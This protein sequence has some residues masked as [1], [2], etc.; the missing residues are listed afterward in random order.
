MRRNNCEAICSNCH[1]ILLRKRYDYIAT[2]NL[3]GNRS[4]CDQYFPWP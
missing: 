4:Y 2:P 3:G 1:E